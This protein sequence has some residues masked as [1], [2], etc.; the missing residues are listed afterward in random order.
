M[1]RWENTS[2]THL[3]R[4]KGLGVF[5]GQGIEKQGGLRHWKQGKGDWIKVW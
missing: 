1:R 3:P 5:M 2:Q 4:G